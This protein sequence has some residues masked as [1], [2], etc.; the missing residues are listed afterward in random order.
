[1]ARKP[2]WQIVTDS[3]DTLGEGVLWNA[4]TGDLFWIDFYGPTLHRLSC[5]G[6]RRDWS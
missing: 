4:P 6:Q 1:M 5:D 2:D 3:R